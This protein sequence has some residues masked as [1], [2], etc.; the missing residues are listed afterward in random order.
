[1]KG[2]WRESYPLGL[3]FAEEM[4]VQPKNKDRRMLKIPPADFPIAALLFGWK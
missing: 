3:S 2:Y 4:D 1:M